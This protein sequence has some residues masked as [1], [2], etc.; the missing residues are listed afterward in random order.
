MGK[1]NKF[2][3]YIIDIYL[4]FIKFGLL[5]EYSNYIMGCPDLYTSLFPP[6]LSHI[7][8]RTLNILDKHINENFT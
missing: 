3:L 2:I 1:L 4:T 5:A 8:V 6:Y 7:Y